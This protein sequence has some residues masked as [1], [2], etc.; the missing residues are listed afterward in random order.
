[1]DRTEWAHALHTHVS[2]A[3]D[4]PPDCC[5]HTVLSTT[6]ILDDDTLSAHWEQ[7]TG[8][9]SSHSDAS[10]YAH[11]VA[12]AATVAADAYAQAELIYPA[13]TP[14]AL[15]AHS[16]LRSTLWR[17]LILAAST[18]LLILSALESP[19]GDNYESDSQISLLPAAKAGLFLLL[20]ADLALNFV[21]G[22]GKQVLSHVW[23]KVHLLVLACLL[24]DLLAHISIA[25]FSSTTSSSSS[26]STTVTTVPQWVSILAT[27][28]R[29]ARISRPLVL[30]VFV[31]RIR[32]DLKLV[33]RTSLI[34]LFSVGVLLVVAL[35]FAASL[36]NRLFFGAYSSADS[37]EEGC[38]SHFD[39]L[40]A[41]L[42]TLVLVVTRKSS[43][44]IM[45]PAYTQVSPLGASAFFVAVFAVSVFI[46]AVVL[47]NG[48][49]EFRA[50]LSRESRR[51]FV[52]TRRA[53]MSAFYLLGKSDRR[54]L[55]RGISVHAMSAYIA[56]LGPRLSTPGS[57][58]LLSETMDAL[59]R[60]V[61]D[62]E[63]RL[64]FLLFAQL[65][66]LAA[67]SSLSRVSS[68]APRCAFLRRR[69]WRPLQERIS[70]IMDS[71]M[72]QALVVAS[73]LAI[74]LYVAVLPDVSASSTQRV[75][76]SRVYGGFLIAFALELAIRAVPPLFWAQ[77]W[78]VFDV[79][80]VLICASA[81]VVLIHAAPGALVNRDMGDVVRPLI[82]FRLLARIRL[83]QV[84]LAAVASSAL[85]MGSTLAI[86]IMIM[87]AF[88][89]LGVELFGG[90][91]KFAGSPV[92]ASTIPDEL[93][94]DT[95]AT[96]SS[97]MFTLLTQAGWPPIISRA[98]AVAGNG[99]VWFF[100][101]YLFSAVVIITNLLR[102]LFVENY[103]GVAALTSSAANSPAPFPLTPG[104]SAHISS[105]PWDAHILSET[106][107][108]NDTQPTTLMWWFGGGAQSPDTPSLQNQ[109]DYAAT[110]AY[111]VGYGRGVGS[112]GGEGPLGEEEGRD[113]FWEPIT[114]NDLAMSS[115]SDLPPSHHPL[116]GPSGS[117]SELDS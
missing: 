39:S 44:Y 86:L 15:G 84:F 46:V 68:Q 87:H 36:G 13:P 83:A 72:V 74:T 77:A 19:A 105:F 50:A 14:T 31:R 38:G 52:K 89:T 80:V 48:F 108:G 2:H 35:A 42:L 82:V 11:S 53:L 115:S 4:A 88:S 12:V 97:T 63:S 10:Q 92:C 85:T 29:C 61:R 54:V 109:D 34:T 28:A 20:G 101:F 60:P 40:P 25:Q 100:I 49:Q 90:P 55:D 110:V 70:K 81:E 37:S 3:A 7:T 94:F 6:S 21:A 65:S 64:D 59:L 78:N 91:G 23:S 41:A 16:A 106:W 9:L 47:A 96:A 26:A 75:Q 22:G 43:P 112:W 45:Y 62:T 17:T 27:V 104:V 76:T 30:P 33:A 8:Y 56:A 95:F 99:A 32:R 24:L 1:M 114:M 113:M 116:S 93:H 57:P 73:I 67:L 71:R 69:A 58:K 66:D 117:S 79:G 111:D 107:A 103:E 51:R 18:S 5:A 98:Q 102:T